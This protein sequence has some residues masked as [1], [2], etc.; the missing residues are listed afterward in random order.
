MS[1]TTQQQNA[2]QAFADRWSERGYEKGETQTYW[3]E[4]LH[5]LL[6]VDSPT[7][8]ILFE[9]PVRTGSTLFIDAYIPATHVLIEQKSLG[10]DLADAYSQACNYA[11]HMV[12]SERPRWIVCC[13]FATLHIYDMELPEP[14][15]KPVV[16]SLADL[17]SQLGALSFLVDTSSDRIQREMAVSLQAGEIVGCLYDALLKQ[18]RSTGGGSTG[19]SPVPQANGQ[20]TQPQ[21]S[22]LS[23]HHSDQEILRWLNILCVRLV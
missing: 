11:A 15:R 19:G 21:A 17:P 4:L 3:L 9:K 13:N 8:F 5:E 7:Q 23:S 22:G 10:S 6:G 16:L 2:A 14:Q 12:F 1:T 20:P 18:Y